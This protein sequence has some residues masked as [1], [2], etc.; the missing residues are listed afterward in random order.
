MPL[1]PTLMRWGEEWAGCRPY[2][3]HSPP[4]GQLSQIGLD[5]QAFVPC[6]HWLL[7][8]GHSRRHRLQARQLSAAEV[9]PGG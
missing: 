7:D 1:T 6:T 2:E 8:T 3:S 4:Q 9:I 5:S